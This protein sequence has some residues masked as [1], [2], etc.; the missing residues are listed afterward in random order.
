MLYILYNYPAY[1]ILPKTDLPLIPNLGSFEISQQ[2]P[3]VV[4]KRFISHLRMS[5]Y[6]P[7][8]RAPMPTQNKYYNVCQTGYTRLKERTPSPQRLVPN[9]SQHVCYQSKRRQHNE[10]IEYFVPVAELD[11]GFDNIVFGASFNHGAIYSRF[12]G[13]EASVFNEVLEHEIFF[14][15]SLSEP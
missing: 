14:V 9:S 12:V 11:F 6:L 5:G 2:V 13:W 3:I 8:R 4:S 10:D 7:N 1:Y 15:P